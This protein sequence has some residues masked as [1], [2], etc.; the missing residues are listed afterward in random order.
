MAEYREHGWG[1]VRGDVVRSA[2]S[3][4]LAA[5]GVAAAIGLLVGWL[6]S[7]ARR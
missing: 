7:R 4:P 1:S 6:G 3:Q 2:R 5:L